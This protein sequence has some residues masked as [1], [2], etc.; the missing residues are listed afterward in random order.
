ML[1][2][3][4]SSS[5]R[6]YILHTNNSKCHGEINIK[7]KTKN[8]YPKKNFFGENTHTHHCKENRLTMWHIIVIKRKHKG[9]RK[10]SDPVKKVIYNILT[11]QKTE[12]RTN[13]S[14]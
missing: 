7:G 6:P 5:Q 9:N 8:I 10:L 14:H 13:N 1:G 4:S 3:H 11:R 12:V 2:K